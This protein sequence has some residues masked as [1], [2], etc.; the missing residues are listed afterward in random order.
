VTNQLWN[1]YLKWLI[2]YK[3]HISS[4]QSIIKKS[5]TSF[6]L[7]DHI[8]LRFVFYNWFGHLRYVFYNWLVTWDMYFIIDWSLEICILE[9]IGH[10]RYFKR[11][12]W[13]PINRCKAAKLPIFGCAVVLIQWHTEWFQ[14]LHCTEGP[15]WVVID[16]S[17]PFKVILLC[18][19]I[20]SLNVWK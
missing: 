14:H 8:P 18:L 2:N 7:K 12:Y 15:V 1:T 6:Q 20:D 17:S 13:E 4:D 11:D 19:Q 3:I 5:T 16:I 9:L 10:L